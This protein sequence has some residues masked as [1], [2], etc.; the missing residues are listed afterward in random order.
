MN[1]LLELSK[2]IFALVAVLGLF[3][4]LMR[5]LKSK[6]LYNQ[7]NQ[8]KILEKCYLGRDKL[9]CLIEVVDQVLLLSV[10][11]QEIKLIKEVELADE[12]DLS[13]AKKGLN[14]FKKG[15]D[16]KND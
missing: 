11:N 5:F 8:I 3:Y 7:T 12:V 10:T 13:Q 4:L 15:K 9:V 1:H 6:E 2:V 14:I 16:E